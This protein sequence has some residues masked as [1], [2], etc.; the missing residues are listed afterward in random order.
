MSPDNKAICR[1]RNATEHM[2]C[3]LKDGRRIPTRF[4]RNITDFMAA[5]A[6]AAAV[7]WWL[8]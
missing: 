4:D 7:I 2:F 1:E 3:R 5:I 6:L 8:Q